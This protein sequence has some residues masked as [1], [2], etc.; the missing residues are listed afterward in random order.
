[1]NRP[2]LRAHLEEF[3]QLKHRE[4]VEHIEKKH[5]GIPDE[6]RLKAY[7]RDLHEWTS[8]T[9]GVPR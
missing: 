2:E 7:H 5:G 9:H 8:S 3:D 1:M 4:K 6:N